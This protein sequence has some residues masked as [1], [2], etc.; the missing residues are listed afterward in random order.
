M[1]STPQ[2]DP[3][4]AQEKEFMVLGIVNKK[5]RSGLVIGILSLSITANVFLV[6]MLISMQGE[7]YE[8]MLQ[9]VDTRVND[10][11]DEP[12]KDLN[13]AIERVGN[14]TQV[15]DSINLQLSKPQQK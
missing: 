9:R 10:K 5:L 15:A 11:L 14:V 12:V 8:K 3:D 7:L 1:S 6:K 13:K 2:K 4:N